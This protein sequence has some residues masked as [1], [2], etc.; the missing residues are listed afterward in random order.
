M[1]T[2]HWSKVRSFLVA[3][4]L[5]LATLLSMAPVAMA[6]T[7]TNATCL[8]VAVVPQADVATHGDG[9]DTYMVTLANRGGALIQGITID[10]P[11]TAGYTL[12]SARFDR[13]NTWVTSL[14]AGKATIRIEG[15]RGVDD[16]VHGT[17]RFSGPT[18]SAANAL[19][20][21]L[22]AHWRCA[23]T[24]YTAYSNAPL[25]GVQPLSIVGAG[26]QRTLS[27]NIFASGEPVTFWYTSPAG[28]S[29]A[30]VVEEGK[31]IIE[32]QQD[33]S[34]ETRI[35]P[36]QAADASGAVTITLRVVG[37]PSGTYTLTAY[38]NWSGATA[39]ALLSIE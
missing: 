13:E 11:I 28:I 15:L 18:D 29:T 20:S 8:S 25:Y 3:G 19:S 12:T 33:D 31:L 2:H 26:A 16:A 32:S 30:L 14:G 9:V 27:S 39:N 7:P 10:V 37:I 35:R 17:L 38:G 23:K 5:A 24:D 34:D 4:G 22:A 6:A 21:R 1:N 36:A